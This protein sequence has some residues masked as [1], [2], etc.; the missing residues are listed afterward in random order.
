MRRGVADTEK[1]LGIVV[2]KVHI[3]GIDNSFWKL[4][5]YYQK[6]ILNM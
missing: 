2:F 3:H 1:L 4:N 5:F 6:K